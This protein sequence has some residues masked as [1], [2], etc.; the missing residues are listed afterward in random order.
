MSK[1]G[2]DNEGVMHTDKFGTPIGIRKNNVCI[3]HDQ[4]DEYCTLSD[5][6]LKIGDVV[7]VVGYGCVII[8]AYQHV[9]NKIYTKYESNDYQTWFCF[10][11]KS[12][13][14]IGTL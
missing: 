2:M 12:L 14:V 11:E 4:I 10:N 1:L 13:E 3:V 9:K 6:G 5:L 8:Q 7:V